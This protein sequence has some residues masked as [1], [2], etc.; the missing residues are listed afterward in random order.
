MGTGD[1]KTLIRVSKDLS[2]QL[3][4]NMALNMAQKHGVKMSCQLYHCKESRESLKGSISLNVINLV[5]KKI[6]QHGNSISPLLRK[7]GLKIELQEVNAKIQTVE[8]HQYFAADQSIRKL[9]KTLYK[10]E[11]STTRKTQMKIN[12]TN[13]HNTHILQA[14]IQVQRYKHLHQKY[15]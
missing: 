3:S 2:Y 7:L 12:F 15:Y 6:R 1:P 9:F 4:E 8:V 5:S 13:T 10:D 14:R 11:C